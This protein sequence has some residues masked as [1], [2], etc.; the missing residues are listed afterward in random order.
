MNERGRI[1][2][3][4]AFVVYAAAYA[5]LRT[6]SDVQA[7]GWLNLA[8]QATLDLLTAVAALRLARRSVGAM[9]RFLWTVGSAACVGIASDAAYGYTINVRGLNP[10][11][12]DGVSLV[13]QVSYMLFLG[14]WALA[15]ASAAW[16]GSRSRRSAGGLRIATVAGL[17]AFGAI[18]LFRYLPLLRASQLSSTA[19]TFHAL[20]TAAQLVGILA[21]VLTLAL[22]SGRMY[23]LSFLGFACLVC[24]DFILRGEEIG[25]VLLPVHS[26]ELGWTL[27]QVMILAALLPATVR[28]EEERSAY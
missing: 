6:Q 27:G 2:L 13:Y 14:T 21:G 19:Q 12:L 4:A 20:F 25:S 16:T 3:I 24:V 18:F 5:F 1:A 23:L 17:L 7:A 11:S 9:Q 26:L 28:A 10:N 22:D 8:V 15:W